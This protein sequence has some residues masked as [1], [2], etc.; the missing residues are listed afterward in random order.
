[1]DRQIGIA[2]TPRQKINLY[3]RIA[4]IQDEEFLDHAKAAE[5]LEAILQ[6][7]GAHEGA[8]TSLIR[9]YRVLDRWED[10]VNLYEKKLRIVTDDK[11]RVELLLAEG[12]VMVEQI[13]SPE[14]ARKVYERVLEI[15]P[16]HGPALES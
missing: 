13:G 4:G 12:R 8:L 9:H 16:Q 10:V 2:A 11:R 3:E 1:L 6:I 14:R 7:D 5:A 15:D